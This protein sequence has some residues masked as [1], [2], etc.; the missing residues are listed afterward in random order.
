MPV[1]CRLLRPFRAFFP[2]LLCLSLVAAGQ[3]PSGN[4]RDLAELQHFPLTIEDVT[5]FYEAMH[6]LSQLQASHPAIARALDTGSRDT[7]V[8]ILETRL[9]SEPPVVDSLASHHLTPRQYALIQYSYLGIAVAASMA[10]KLNVPPAKLATDL[11]LNPANLDFLRVHK[12]ELAALDRKY[13]MTG[14]D[15]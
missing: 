3:S 15:D 11:H 10:A 12:A 7:G 9:S 5:H 8:S 14:N 2:L 6:D 4:A 13:P 1:C